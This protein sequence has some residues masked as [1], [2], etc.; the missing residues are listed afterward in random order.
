[1]SRDMTGGL[2][3]VEYLIKKVVPGSYFVFVKLFSAGGK[4]LRSL[5]FSL[6]KLTVY[7]AGITAMVKIYTNFG[8][9]HEEEYSAVVK[10]KAEKEII[11]VA[12]IT[13]Y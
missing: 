7:S 13:S 2:G 3:P 4:K 8:T 12:T 9:T 10:L 6:S 5:P 11:Q 1:M